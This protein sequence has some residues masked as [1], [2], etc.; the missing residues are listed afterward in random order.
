MALKHAVLGLLLERPG[1]GY[2]LM[3]RLE[4]RLGPAW[5]LNP[6]TVYAALDQLEK[7]ELIVGRQ[8]DE[9]EPETRMRRRV[10]RVVYEVT[11]PGK[12]AF[13]AWMARP[14][15]Q[16]EPIRGELQLKVAAA[17]PE[18]VPALLNSIDHAELLTRML[19]EECSACEAARDLA[20]GPTAGLAHTAAVLRLEGELH[21]LERARAS[22]LKK[23][24]PLERAGA[25]SNTTIRGVVPAS[26]RAE[27]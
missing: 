14:T 1:Y 10:R 3:Q 8:P 18:D 7:E 5:Q 11:E 26:A 20:A 12:V 2:D 21:W 25:P 15:V 17:R 23:A 24:P 16:L 22:L 13:E 19:W 27:G 4:T 9:E 6:S